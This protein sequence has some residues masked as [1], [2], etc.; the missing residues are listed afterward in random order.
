MSHTLEAQIG[1]SAPLSPPTAR[2]LMSAARRDPEDQRA[3]ASRLSAVAGAE[4]SVAA[5]TAIEQELG[6]VR[7]LARQ[8]AGG[9][10]RRLALPEAAV[11]AVQAALELAR[12]VALLPDGRPRLASAEQVYERFACLSLGPDEV[13][14]VACLDATNHLE[15]VIPFAGGGSAVVLDAAEV[16][17]RCLARG[18]RR[19]VLVHPHPGGSAE[20]S[21]ADLRVTRRLVRAA[22]VVGISVLDHVIIGHGGYT[23]LR[24]RGAIRFG[25]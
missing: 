17:R 7:G 16:L 18:A 11:R 6:G 12:E 20:P 1:A 2:P 13:L 22:R 9:L 24:E 4:V 25:R 21:A 15:D 5:V 23:S 3:L 14:A 8:P 10:A 19:I